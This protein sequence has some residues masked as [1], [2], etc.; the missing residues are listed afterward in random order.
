MKFNENIQE[1]PG[2][3]WIELEQTDSFK[4]ALEVIVL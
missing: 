2:I 3:H 1:R 4:N